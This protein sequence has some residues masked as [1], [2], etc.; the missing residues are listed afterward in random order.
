MT[1]STFVLLLRG[2]PQ[3]AL[4]T[5]IGFICLLSAALNHIWSEGGLGHSNWVCTPHVWCQRRVCQ[6]LDLQGIFCP[7]F[8]FKFPPPALD[9]C[10]RSAVSFSFGLA[11]D[12]GT[13][14]SPLGVNELF[15]F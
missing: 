5:G 8:V 11:V 4:S 13:G 6:L 10:L 14:C 15:N 12:I 2:A 7:P 1:I 9:I 3:G